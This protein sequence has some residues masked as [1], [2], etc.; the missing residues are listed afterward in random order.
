M[1]ETNRATVQSIFLAHFGVGFFDPKI[2]ELKNALGRL[3]F[4]WR[5]DLHPGFLA[6]VLARPL[7]RESGNFP[8]VTT[9]TKFEALPAQ[10]VITVE[11]FIALE[12]P[13]MNPGAK[14]QESAT[15]GVHTGNAVLLFAFDAGAR[16]VHLELASK[17]SFEF[18][19]PHLAKSPLLLTI[20]QN[21]VKIHP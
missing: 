20:R 16:N 13:G 2:K 6:S 14:L 19:R 3:I 8:A 12:A 5:L 11:K 15:D 1:I 21:V 4:H 10:T 17:I 18:S 9:E 7:D